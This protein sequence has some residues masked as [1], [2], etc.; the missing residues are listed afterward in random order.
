M[1]IG[2]IT[3]HRSANYGSVLQAF[4][5]QETIKKLGHDVE[6]IDYSPSRYTILAML[7]GLKNK[8]EL[9][10][11]HLSIRIIVK[12]IMYP[13]YVLRYKTFKSFIRKYLDLSKEQYRDVADFEK[14]L[15][16]YDIY[17]TGSDQV[18]NSE[19]N[20]MIDGPLFLSF[21]PEGSKRIAYAASFGKD[22]LEP[23]EVKETKELLRKYDD[24]SVR[25]LDGKNILN[26][27]GIKNSRC[28][29]D[30]TLLIDG[31]RWKKIASK[32]FENENYILVYNLN[33]NRK[34]H[35][36]AE[37]LSKK[38]GYKIKYITYQLHDFYKKGKMYCNVSV[39][40]YLALVANAKYVVTDSFHGVAFSINFN[41]DFVVVYPKKFSSR[42]RSILEIAGLCDRVI[43]GI[44]D[45]FSF[46][47]IDYKEV[48]R[49]IPEKKKESMNYL[50]EALNGQ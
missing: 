23:W 15:T 41:R 37:K 4:A 44:N 33:R 26:R 7:K 18:W 46:D 12:M 47:K 38:T 21:V 24:I 11:N 17:C 8:N 49:R 32:K 9:I 16:H 25:E 14:K 30:P 48:N 19:W 31:D 20:G 3:L 35:A 39:E 1:R 29:L 34:I 43:N 5:L 50:Q 13:S 45:D 6:I 22:K 27:L 42:L 10:R 36:Y 40:D 2:I 28:V